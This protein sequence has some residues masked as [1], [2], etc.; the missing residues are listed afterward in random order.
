MQCKTT[1]PQIITHRIYLLWTL[2][3]M[4]LNSNDDETFLDQLCTRGV[5]LFPTLSLLK[6]LEMVMTW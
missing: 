3:G 2:T 5:P 4:P 1:F 6:E